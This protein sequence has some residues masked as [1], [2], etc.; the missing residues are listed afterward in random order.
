MKE[1]TGKW[2]QSSGT[3]KD[4]MDFFDKENGLFVY[5]IDRGHYCEV[6][7]NQEEKKNPFDLNLAK[8]FPLLIEFLKSTSF[9]IVVFRGSGKTFSSGG[10]FQF[11]QDRVQDSSENN[12]SVMMD[13]YQSFLK[14]RELPQ[15]SI[16]L[17]EGAAI[18]AGLCFALACDL[19]LVETKA[20]LALNFVHLGLNPGM[21]AWPLSKALFGES[22]AKYLL[23]SG[24]RFNG[25]DLYDWG[26]ANEVFLQEDSEVLERFI[27]QFSKSSFQ[28]VSMLKEEIRSDQLFP[29][30]LQKE[31]QGQ[32]VC[33]SGE[34]Y[35]K[36]LS[37]ALKR[38]SKHSK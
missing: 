29:N 6:V 31:A 8:I 1:L 13:F 33:F 14:V 9:K 20:K 28:A 38:I 27:E 7:F 36:R 24:T 19:R 15:I 4:K 21:G 12:Q 35:Q 5:V 37:G 32:S 16:A 17:I 25:Q 34:D 3:K 23:M 22:K 11:L 18:G 10:D 30:Y 2:I 26:G